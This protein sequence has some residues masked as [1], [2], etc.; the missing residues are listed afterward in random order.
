M[1]QRS[2]S[3]PPH[4][5]V[6]PF[7]VQSHV[8]VMLNLAE[9]FSISGFQVT[10]LI[11]DHIQ[12]GPRFDQISSRFARY[13]ALYFQA[14]S[15]GLPLDHP[16][17]GDRVK[18]L[19]DSINVTTKPQF[20]HVL[21]SRA[22]ISSNGNGRAPLTCI[23]AD[24]IMSFTIDIAKD[25]GLRTILFRPFS[26]TCFWTLF[27]VPKLIQAGELPLKEDSDMDKLVENI[28]GMERVLRV[29]DLPSFCRVEDASDPQLQHVVSETHRAT[30]A[31]GLILNTLED[32]EEPALAR[33]RANFPKLYV[34][35]PLHGYFRPLRSPNSLSEEGRSCIEWLDDQPLKSVVFVSFGNM[36]V[37]KSQQLVEFWHG[38]VN[39]GKPFLWVV[40]ANL[41]AGCRIPTEFI[42]GSGKRGKVVDWAPQEEV[43]SHP[44]TG[45][46]LTHGGWNSTLESI[47]EGVPM[48]CWPFYADQ[49]VNS[50]LVEEVWRIGVDMKDIC[51]RKTVE[52]AVRELME[53]RREEL[54]KSSK[55]MARLARTSIGQGGSSY[56]NLD[57]L[58]K[59]I[60]HMSYAK[61]T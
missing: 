54:L 60:K 16:R 57:C 50:R 7:P 9:I 58:I 8:N 46:F 2:T 28:L 26:A 10:F 32:L 17:T 5:L 13:P 51:D 6:F 18:E 4:V 37:L 39:S 11:P 61:S 3:I 1:E 56:V 29:R 48:I 22:Q 53:V 52:K 43:L 42:D 45:G 59:D 44:A 15:D 55:E 21:K 12:T 19:F 49:Q 30:C 27:C 34:I 36:T 38:L 24:G 23:I 14:I 31:H 25:F 47:Y 33:I 35:G 20:R 40:P 41:T